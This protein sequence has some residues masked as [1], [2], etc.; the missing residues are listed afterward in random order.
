MSFA[1]LATDTVIKP[2][3]WSVLP[4]AALTAG[5]REGQ[6]PLLDDEPRY[7][8]EG[9]V[10]VDGRPVEGAEVRLH[11]LPV[12][13]WTAVPLAVTRRDGSFSIRTNAWQAGVAAGEYRVTVAWRPE[14]IR[15]EEFTPGPNVL[16]S[17]LADPATTPLRVTVRPGA[18]QLEPWR[19][20]RCECNG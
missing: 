9:Q 19:L 7:T 1:Q 8:V 13:G 17:P 5:A 12:A 11:S 2:I 4:A 16:R 15:G 3:A 18:N 10:L 6:V 14:V 20:T